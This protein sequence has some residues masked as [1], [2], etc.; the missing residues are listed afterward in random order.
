MK[1]LIIVLIIVVAGWFIV[2]QIAPK[3]KPD[4]VITKYGNTLKTDEDKAK[5]AA[6]TADAA[7]LQGAVNSY[8]ASN[9]KAPE[10]LQELV[11]KGFLSHIPPGDFTYDAGTGAVG[12]K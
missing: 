3:A 9:G 11:E 7:I 8:R 2:K 4:D 10:S 5:A 6:F 12:T 1:N